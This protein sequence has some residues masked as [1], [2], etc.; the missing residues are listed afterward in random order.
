MKKAIVILALILITASASHAF[1]PNGMLSITDL[2]GRTLV[3]PV[4]PEQPVEEVLPFDQDAVFHQ[5]LQEKFSRVI[6]ISRMTK[7]EPDADDIPQS[8]RHIIKK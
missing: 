1:N 8:L 5:V 3:M 6:D 4:K 2:N 7:P